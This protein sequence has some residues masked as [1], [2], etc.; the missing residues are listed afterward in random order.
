MKEIIV[1]AIVV[2]L[3]GAA[4]RIIAPY[5]KKFVTWLIDRLVQMAERKITESGMGAA[6]KAWVLKKLKIF[7]VAATDAICEA[8]DIS[9][10]AMN[11]KKADLQATIKDDVAEQI[12]NEVEDAT[13]SITNRL[14]NAG[15]N[16]KG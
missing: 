8:I 11:S 13:T 12:T 1:S 4:A 15:K 6:K 5:S 2:G 16:L 3:L 7:G 9:V 14:T 10:S